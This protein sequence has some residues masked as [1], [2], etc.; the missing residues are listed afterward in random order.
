MCSMVAIPTATKRGSRKI[1]SCSRT[2]L[3]PYGT[4][5]L[6]VFPVALW[7]PHGSWKVLGSKASERQMER[8]FNSKT[9]RTQYSMPWRYQGSYPPGIPRQR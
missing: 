5:R 4:V 9:H 6:F 7:P 8:R 3:E 1:P 2:P